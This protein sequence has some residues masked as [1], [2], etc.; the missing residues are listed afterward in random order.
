MSFS[1]DISRGAF[2]PEELAF[3]GSEGCNHQTGAS[4]R[5]KAIM[6]LPFIVPLKAPHHAEVSLDNRK[7]SLGLHNNFDRLLIRSNTSPPQ[8]TVRLV[9]RGAKVTPPKNA[10]TKRERLKGVA[11]YKQQEVFQTTRAAL[12]NSGQK[13]RDCISHLSEFIFSWQRSLPYLATWVMHPIS[14]HDLGIVYY[15][16]EVLNPR[17]QETSLGPSFSA[18][19]PAR[20]GVKP[21]FHAP[22]KALE[23]Q[24]PLHA[25]AD[26]LLAEASNAYYRN[27]RRL[28]ISNA[29]LAVEILSNHVFKIKQKEAFVSQGVSDSQADTDV[30]ELSRKNNTDLG[31]LLHR[32]LKTACSRSLFDE[33]NA[34]YNQVIQCKKLRNQVQHLGYLPSPSECDTN[35]SAA[36][37]TVRW[38]NGIIGELPKPMYPDYVD[39]ESLSYEI[40][41]FGSTLSL[42]KEKRK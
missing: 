12:A 23:S 30:E 42:V 1:I 20:Q 8:D 26:E 37:E 5:W 13:I 11:I 2:G 39:P 38:L 9:E 14:L 31:F 4:F 10:Q 35:F 32:G 18:F 28:S 3:M 19:N 16:L 27:M 24:N 22:P 7:Y 17:T 40:D 25:L 21:L 36:C 34:T 33:D 15:M 41:G 29:Y 6:S